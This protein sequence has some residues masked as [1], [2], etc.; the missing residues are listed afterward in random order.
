MK[1]STSKPAFY[2]RTLDEITDLICRRRLLRCEPVIIYGFH[3]STMS[4]LIAA[5]LS[6]EGGIVSDGMVIMVPPS[7]QADVESTIRRI[8]METRVQQFEVVGVRFWDS[9]ERTVFDEEFGPPLQ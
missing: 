5:R 8:G 9:K 3:F 4:D 1:N 7:Q 2:D 6:V